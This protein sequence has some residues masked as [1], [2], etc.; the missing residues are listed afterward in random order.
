MNKF[1]IILFLVVVCGFLL[2][3]FFP[4]QTVAPTSSLISVSGEIVLGPSCPVQR[5]GDE[6]NCADEAYETSILVTGSISCVRDDSCYN[7]SQEIFSDYRGRFSI[8]LEPGR[9]VFTPAGGAVLPLCRPKEI[10]VEEAS[11]I[12]D[13]VLECDTGIR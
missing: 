11:P 4:K 12:D 6:T 3:F 10:L 13:L 9:Y 7:F 8:K 2:Y 5:A 1:F